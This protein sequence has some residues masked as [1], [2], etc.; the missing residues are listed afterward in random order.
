MYQNVLI[1][2]IARV[3][4]LFLQRKSNQLDAMSK[5][6]IFYTQNIELTFDILDHRVNQEKIQNTYGDDVKKAKCYTFLE[7]T[8]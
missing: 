1:Y 4:Y 3:K 2:Y 7:H 8:E 5:L 6:G